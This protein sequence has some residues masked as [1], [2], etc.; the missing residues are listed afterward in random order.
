MK[1]LLERIKDEKALCSIYNI[2]GEPTRFSV[3][4][5]LNI[6]EKSVLIQAVSPYGADDG[7][8]YC[9]ISDIATVEIDTEYLKDIKIL[10]EYHKVTVGAFETSGNGNLAD[11]IAYS[12]NNGL[13]CNIEIF[14]EQDRTVCG[15]INGA[16][17]NLLKVNVIDEHGRGAGYA[18]IAMNEISAIVVQSEDER[19][20]NILFDRKN[21]LMQ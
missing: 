4:Y 10:A 16:D 18:Y 9:L 1:H 17:G 14:H 6:D 12:Q 15:I 21:K 2:D 7:I 3:G 8:I 11:V 19:K 5:I 20:L 13:I